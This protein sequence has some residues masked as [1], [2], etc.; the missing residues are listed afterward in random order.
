MNMEA[1]YLIIS[2]IAIVFVTKFTIFNNKNL[3]PSP[4]PCLP[5]IGH[6]YLVK[7]PLYR[8]L[9]K[10]S[11]RHGPMLML[12]FGTRRAL[13]VSSPAAVEEC[14][15]TNDVTFA[16]RPHLLAGKHLGY[17]YTT[18]S[19]SSYGDQWRNLRRIASLELLSAHRLQTLSSIRSE[20]VLLLAKKVYGRA[21]T[22]GVVEMK[23]MFFELMLNV[24]MMMI[25]GKRYYGDSGA[26]VEEARRFKEIVMETFVLMETTN[27]SDYLPWWKW[28]G[29]RGLERKMVALGVKRSVFMQGLLEE[30]K[31]KMVVIKKKEDKSNL[32]EVLLKLQQTEPE[33]YTNEVIKGLM[34]VL[35]SAGTDTSS[36]TMEWMLSLLLNNPEALKK[37]QAEIDNN[38]GE[39]RLVNESDIAS[40][41][42]LRCIINETMRMYPPGPLVF[43]ESSKD[44]KVGGYHI[45]GG[46]MLLMN[47]WA[48]QNDPKNWDD[49]KKFKPERFIGLEDSRDGY[50]L[51]PFG[52]GRRRCPAENLAMR[53]IGLTLGTLIQCFEWERTSEEMVDMTE[54]KGLTMP[55]AKPLVAKCQPRVMITKLMSQM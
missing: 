13:L 29:G 9:G 4:F 54:G 39:D 18:L 50:K 27:V 2:I 24:M 16:N 17:D 12:R 38:V 20:E 35:L 52:S 37:A 5:I 53:M 3:P 8:A 23:S 46:T 26:D 51:M 44:C 7:S 32:M 10:L 14:L 31:R 49:P 33:Y 34:Q 21:V 11:N 47:L 43:H 45:P 6:L 36:G 19:W 41:P 55:K 15:T 1:L 28:V 42:Y 40:L 25:A 48:M 30:H 22:D